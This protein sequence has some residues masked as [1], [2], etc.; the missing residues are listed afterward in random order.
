MQRTILTL[1][2]ILVLGMTSYAQKIVEGQYD[3]IKR[4]A[5]KANGISLELNGTEEAIDAILQK[6]IKAEAGT[7]V[8]TL[9][10]GIRGAEASRLPAISSSTYDYYYKLEPTG[11]KNESITRLTFYVSAGNYNF[12]SSKKYPNEMKAAGQWLSEISREVMLY[13]QQLY[14]D[15]QARNVEKAEKHLTELIS[16]RK[17]WKLCWLKL[18][19]SWKKICRIRL[20]RNNS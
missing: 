19:Q 12:L 14:I 6:K 1:T 20:R 11:K 15:Q 13:Q 10:S 7:K 3:F 2:L 17:N 18:K 16:E 5:N 4:V 9:K 8:K